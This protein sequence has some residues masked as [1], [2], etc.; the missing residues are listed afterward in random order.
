M[1]TLKIEIP[2]GYEIDEENS[3]FKKIVFKEVIN[4][5]PL[6]VCYVKGRDW[7]IDSVGYITSTESKTPNQLSTEERAEAFLSLMQLVE[8]R[9]AWN[10]IDGGKEWSFDECNY[11]IDVF[12]G[13]LNKENYRSSYTVLHFR[14]E[15]TRDKFLK[16]FKDLINQAK[17]L[18]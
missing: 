9:D 14:K 3:T 10:E 15:E 13:K 8:L 2:E 7:Y 17:E 1:K 16:T 11:V 6:S 18:I 12:D 5:Y 4:D